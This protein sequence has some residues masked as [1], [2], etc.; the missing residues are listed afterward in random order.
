LKRAEK[1]IEEDEIRGLESVLT[2]VNGV[3]VHACDFTIKSFG[4]PK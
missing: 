1:T 2:M 4:E 3:V